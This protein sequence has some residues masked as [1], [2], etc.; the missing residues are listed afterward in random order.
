MKAILI[1]LLIFTQCGLQ[2]QNNVVRIKAGEDAAVILAKEIYLY[3][4]FTA[5]FVFF[6]DGLVT[7][8]KLNY[9]TLVNE[10]HFIGERGDTL[11]LANEKT[12][13]FILVGADTFYFGDFYLRQ[14]AT[15]ESVKL[16]S[17]QH[18]KVLDKQKIGAYDQP[19]SNSSISS[20]NSYT[21]GLMR[22]KINVKEDILMNREI[23][24]YFGDRFNRFFP[25][26][27]KNLLRMFA[28]DSSPIEDIVRKLKTDFNKGEDLTK[29]VKALKAPD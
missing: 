13:K 3:P 4:E 15:S 22:Y 27:K 8:G 20:Y 26:T 11:A 10:M 23:R 2:A 6:R 24:Y 5:G 9:N 7:A 28:K 29:L 21:N 1:F 17:M 12:I 19:T 18:L 25:A 16:L 14:I